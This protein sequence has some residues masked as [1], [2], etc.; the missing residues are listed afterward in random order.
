[1]VSWDES[2]CAEYYT[3]WHESHDSKDFGNISLPM[4]QADVILTDLL[5][6]TDYTVYVTAVLG[7]EFSDEAEADF[8]T[9]DVIK[10]GEVVSA[11]KDIKCH[12]GKRECDIREE[13][14]KEDLVIK[15]HNKKEGGEDRDMT[16]ME[17]DIT[18]KAQTIKQ[19]KIHQKTETQ[20][21][22]SKAMSTYGQNF[23]G[24]ITQFVLLIIVL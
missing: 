13:F 6:N 22:S 8:T 12:Y 23:C 1:M 11:D 18:T 7:E 14:V 17:Q 15:D 9:D 24:I 2:S 21:Q 20:T 5:N 16:T 19:S 10:H 3:V 4:G